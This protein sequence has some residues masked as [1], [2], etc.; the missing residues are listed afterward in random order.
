MAEANY[1][2]EHLAKNV[3]HL[4]DGRT[5]APNPAGAPGDAEEDVL[6]QASNYPDDMGA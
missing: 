2:R 1:R 4:W 6:L 5:W 3:P